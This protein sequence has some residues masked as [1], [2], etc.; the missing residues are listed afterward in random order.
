M[1][2][3]NNTE[4]EKT[5]SKSSNYWIKIQRQFVV[6]KTHSKSSKILHKTGCFISNQINDKYNYKQPNLSK[7]K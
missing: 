3:K 1:C 5:F 2:W 4:G 7:N 6:N